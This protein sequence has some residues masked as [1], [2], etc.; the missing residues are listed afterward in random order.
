MWGATAWA[1]SA[2]IDAHFSTTT[3]ESSPNRANPVAASPSHS[4]SRPAR[5][6]GQS[7]R[8]PAQDLEVQVLHIDAVGGF[9]EAR[10]L[11]VGTGGVL[12]VGGYPAVFGEGK[13]MAIGL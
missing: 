12:Q 7:A 1:C 3:N 11:G 5:S 13:D 8:L 4:N 9:G 6:C 2:C 10:G